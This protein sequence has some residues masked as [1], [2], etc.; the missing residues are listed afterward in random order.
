MVQA[1]KTVKQRKM[2][3]QILPL[4]KG[5]LSME[6]WGSHQQL[7]K[8]MGRG[9]PT[10]ALHP[11]RKGVTQIPEG[12][13]E[14]VTRSQKLSHEMETGYDSLKEPMDVGRWGQN[15]QLYS[16]LSSAHC[17]SLASTPH[18]HTAHCKAGI[19]KGSHNTKTFLAKCIGLSNWFLWVIFL[20]LSHH[21]VRFGQEGQDFYKL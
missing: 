15:S 9:N 12:H 5:H 3:S 11:R 17:Q 20:I 10:T 19:L 16:V 18:G 2:I 1:I 4:P 8:E 7:E 14:K 21:K 6:A 13:S